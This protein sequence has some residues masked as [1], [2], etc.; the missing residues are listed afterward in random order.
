MKVNCCENRKMLHLLVLRAKLNILPPG[1]PD[2][3]SLQSEINKLEKE[4]G[5]A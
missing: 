1:S 2:A 4:L 3:A 5:L